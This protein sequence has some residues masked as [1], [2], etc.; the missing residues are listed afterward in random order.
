M[1]DRDGN[2]A[3]ACR[4]GSIKLTTLLLETTLHA[5]FVIRITRFAGVAL[6]VSGARLA[7]AGKRALARLGA[8]LAGDQFAYGRGGRW[9]RRGGRWRGGV[10]RR[11]RVRW[12]GGRGFS[13][14]ADRCR[15]RL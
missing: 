14:R 2:E 6:G 11:R 13:G 1:H 9:R 15:C 4:A 7:A 3:A 10:G 5:L 12:R 8:V